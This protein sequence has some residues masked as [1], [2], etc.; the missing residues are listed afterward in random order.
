M[1]LVQPPT[2]VFTGVLD[3][4]GGFTGVFAFVGV[5]LAGVFFAAG[6]GSSG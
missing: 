5:F 6:A 1:Q 3:L 4:A 2:G